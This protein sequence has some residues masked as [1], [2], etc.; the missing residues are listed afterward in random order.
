MARANS[1]RRPNPGGL[2]PASSRCH[3]I[4]HVSHPLFMWRRQTVVDS[5]STRFGGIK[6]TFL[7]VRKPLLPSLTREL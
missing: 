5:R 1:P 7:T 2:L 3:N 4:Y 6:A